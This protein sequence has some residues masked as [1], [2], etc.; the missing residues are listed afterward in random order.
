MI[1]VLIFVIVLSVVLAAVADL[2]SGSLR[3]TVKFRDA[4][5]ENHALDAAVN[6]A[7][8]RIREDLTQGR[9]PGYTNGVNVCNNYNAPTIAGVVVT[10][11]CGGEQSVQGQPDSGG[12]IPINNPFN[13]PSEALFATALAPEPGITLDANGTFR[14]HGGVYSTSNIAVSNAELRVEGDVQANGPC[15]GSIFRLDPPYPPAGPGT[16]VALDC[17]S[18]DPLAPEVYDAAVSTPPATRTAPGCPA[19]YLVTLNPGYLPQR[20][21]SKRS[22]IRKLHWKD[23]L[24]Q[25]R[26]LP[27]R[28][29]Q[30]REPCVVR[31]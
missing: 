8:Q 4:R 13:K 18:S 7:I 31:R 17:D 22:D 19:G 3:S 24:V 14:V 28:L 16:P 29:H 30:C 11:T 6:G 25:A 23:S 9:A 27:V 26:R 15:T 21:G 12:T 20:Q 5:A 1:L 2:S 10:V